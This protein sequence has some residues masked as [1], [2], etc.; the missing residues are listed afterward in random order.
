MY[1]LECTIPVLSVS[2]GYTVYSAQPQCTL[3][4]FSVGGTVWSLKLHCTDATK[5]T[6]QTARP[7][8]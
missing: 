6:R 7:A 1:S 8:C 2:V 3:L 4:V 5:T